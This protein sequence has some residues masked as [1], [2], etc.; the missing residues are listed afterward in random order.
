MTPEQ[1]AIKNVGKQVR[2]Y[3]INIPGLE[4]GRGHQLRVRY[5]SVIA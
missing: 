5:C 1:L 2:F 3:A 4:T